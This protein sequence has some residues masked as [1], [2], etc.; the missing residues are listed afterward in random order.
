MSSKI[1]TFVLGVFVA[2]VIFVLTAVL[3]L[4]NK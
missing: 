3:V 2:T 1:G 4:Y